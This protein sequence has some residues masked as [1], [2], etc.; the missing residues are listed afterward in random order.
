MSAD[1]TNEQVTLSVKGRGLHVD[2]ISVTSEKPRRG[3][4][5]RVYRH[6][7]SSATESNVTRWKKP[8]TVTAGMTRFTM[9]SWKINRNFPHGTWLCAVARKASGNPCIKVH[10]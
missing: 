1:D 2:T 7:G 5:F 9:A 8:R 4:R 10:R 3:E 6:T